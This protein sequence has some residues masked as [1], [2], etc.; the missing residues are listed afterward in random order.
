MNVY[1]QFYRVLTVIH[2]NHVCTFWVIFLAWVLTPLWQWNRWLSVLYCSWCHTSSDSSLIYMILLCVR[3][4]GIVPTIDSS[5]DLTTVSELKNNKIILGGV[6]LLSVSLLL[7]VSHSRFTWYAFPVHYMSPCL[8]LG[9]ISQNL[10]YIQLQYDT[11]IMIFHLHSFFPRILINRNRRQNGMQRF[12]TTHHTSR[13]ASD[14]ADGNQKSQGQPPG[15][16]RTL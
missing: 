14:T 5:L 13:M 12:F 3:F 6:F 7:C 15:I 4:L 8:F 10:Q 1:I 2:M 9:D 16:Y 11:L